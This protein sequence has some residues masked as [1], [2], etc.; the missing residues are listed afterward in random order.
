MHA[1]CLSHANGRGTHLIYIYK[2][3]IQIEM[4]EINW[5]WPEMISMNMAF[6]CI[7]VQNI[8]CI[9]MFINETGNQSYLEK[10]TTLPH[11]PLRKCLNAYGVEFNID[12]PWYM[13]ENS[14]C[15]LINS[16]CKFRII[17]VYYV[18]ICFVAIIYYESLNWYGLFT[19][20]PQG[21]IVMCYNRFCCEQQIFYSRQSRHY[22]MQILTDY[23]N[24]HSHITEKQ[25][26]TFDLWKCALKISYLSQE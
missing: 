22:S 14:P 17:S 19:Q 1:A 9:F 3:S 25:V 5:F 8:K 20:H 16:T 4:T 7:F 11:I 23:K 18:F 6:R 24:D 21:K 15:S 26:N 2:Y 12:I 10:I 13:S